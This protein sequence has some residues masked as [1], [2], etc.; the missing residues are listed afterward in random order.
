[1]WELD[2]KKKAE[3]RKIDT[4]NVMLGKTLESPFNYSSS[5]TNY[6]WTT[7]RSN[8]SILKKSVL[9]I[10]RTDVEAQ[11]PILWSPDV[12]NWLIG[13]DPDAGKDWRQEEKGVTEDEI[14]GWHHQFSGHE[15]E[16]APGVGDGQGSLACCSLWG[17][18]EVDTTERLNCYT[19]ILVKQS[20][21]CTEEI[22][23][24]L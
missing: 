13:K 14:V 3:R 17:H 21:C 19:Y 6:S 4:L 11:A 22:N 15:F 9:N 18:K 16:P 1:M 5:S 8:Q 20:L 23:T 2:Y 24:A 12:K 10:G 7:R